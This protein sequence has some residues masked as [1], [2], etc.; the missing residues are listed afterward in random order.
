MRLF[1]TIPIFGTIIEDCFRFFMNF[2]D[3]IEHLCNIM[4]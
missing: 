4:F 2:S 1:K 3:N